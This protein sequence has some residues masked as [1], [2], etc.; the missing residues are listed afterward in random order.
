MVVTDTLDANLD[1]TTRRWKSRSATL[2]S[3]IDNGTFQFASRPTVLDYRSAITKTWWV[4]VNLEIN[5]FRAMCMPPSAPSTPDT[6]ALPEDALAG[7]LP[8][9]DA[10]HRGEGHITFAILPKLGLPDHTV[11]TNQATIAFDTRIP[12]S[13][14]PVT[15]TVVI[16]GHVDIRRAAAARASRGR[17]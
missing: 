13:T 12:M 16:P 9:N 17:T 3:P 6:G 14:N 8:P 2:S 7:F 10:T 4:D 11:V 1:W 5:L 15:N